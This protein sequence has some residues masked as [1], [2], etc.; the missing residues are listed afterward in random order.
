MQEQI[1]S[2][3]TF[4]DTA[5]VDGIILATRAANH[6]FSQFVLWVRHLDLRPGVFA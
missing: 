1:C 4:A 6:T 5:V 3:G 2:D